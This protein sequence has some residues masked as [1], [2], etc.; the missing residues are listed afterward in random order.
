MVVVLVERAGAAGWDEVDAE[1]EASAVRRDVTRAVGVGVGG[2][3]AGCAAGMLMRRVD[4][5]L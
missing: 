5:A 3:G 1:M 4:C 2:D